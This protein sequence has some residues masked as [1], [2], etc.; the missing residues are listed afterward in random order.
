MAYA[1]GVFVLS[2]D[3][4]VLLLTGKLNIVVSTTAFPNGHIR[5]QIRSSSANP[6]IPPMRTKIV[7]PCAPTY[8]YFPMFN[9]SVVYVKNS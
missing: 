3:Q 7:S 4:W 9:E 6:Q 8:G 5:G 1:R 2:Y